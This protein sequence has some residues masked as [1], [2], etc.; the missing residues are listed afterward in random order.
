MSISLNSQFGISYLIFYLPLSLSFSLGLKPSTGGSDA[1]SSTATTTGDKYAALASLDVTLKELRVKEEPL[2]QPSPPTQHNAM[3][4]QQM[5]GGAGGGGGGGGGSNPFGAPAGVGVQ[6]QPGQQ[7]FNPFAVPQSQPVTGGGVR[8]V[9]PGYGGVFQGAPGVMSGGAQQPFQSQ[10][11]GAFSGQQ[12]GQ[13]NMGQPIQQMGQQPM[14]QWQQQ[15]P[16]GQQWGQPQAFPGQM[17]PGQWGAQQAGMQQAAMQQQQWRPTGQPPQ[18]FGGG[19]VSGFGMQP[20]QQQ[21]M[22]LQ[23]SQFGGFVSASNP[24]QMATAQPS[25]HQQ[26]AKSFGTGGG[27]GFN[28]GTNVPSSSQQQHGSVVASSASTSVQTSTASSSARMGWSTN[29]AKQAPSSSGWGSSSGNATSDPTGW[30]MSLQNVPAAAPGGGGWGGGGI[31][32]SARGGGGWGGGGGMSAGGG[33]GGGGMSAG[34]GGGWVSTGGWGGAQPQQQQNWGTTGNQP[35][36][37]FTVHELE[38]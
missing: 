38:A 17:V 23:Q 31:G 13:A 34:G 22:A 12:M 25:Q 19:N 37:P 5:F 10:Q 9:G 20:Q 3:P 1:Q 15:Q 24:Q 36:N 16:V 26:Q 4:G 32:M 30:S 11:F 2:P 28:W 8:A 18:M 6:P 33:W 27:G 14:A 7:Q 21:Q 29:L 35:S